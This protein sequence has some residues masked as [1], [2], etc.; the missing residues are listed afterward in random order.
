M[1]DATEIP[2]TKWHLDLCWFDRDQNCFLRL[3][4]GVGVCVC[5]CVCVCFAR[6]ANS[7]VGDDRPP[8]LDTATAARPPSTQQ[9]HTT[10]RM[11][12]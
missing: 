11:L 3:E 2:F 9:L 8:G 4:R 6:A 5:V 12:I 1:N 7:W 10:H